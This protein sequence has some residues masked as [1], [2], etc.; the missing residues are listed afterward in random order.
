MNEDKKFFEKLKNESNDFEPIFHDFYFNK[1]SPISIVQEALNSVK[2]DSTKENKSSI[3][4][5]SKLFKES[6]KRK[7]NKS[8]NR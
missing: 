5:P 3:L 6:E 1:H 8:H 4:K 7:A 2:S